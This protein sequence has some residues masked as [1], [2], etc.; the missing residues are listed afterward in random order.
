MPIRHFTKKLEHILTPMMVQWIFKAMRIAVIFLGAAIILEIWGIAVGPLLAGFGLFGVAVALGAQDF[1]KNLIAGMT[2]IAEKRFEPGDWV[3]VDGVVEGTVES[4]GFRSTAIRRF[5]KA[6]VHVPNAQLSDTALTNFS[7]MTHRRIYW[8]IGVVYGSSVEQLKIVRDGIMDYIQNN[9]AFD[10]G[11]STFVRIDSFN[12][13]S[14]DI[15]V[16]CFTK[17]TDW[18]EWLDIKEQFAFEVKDIV[19]SRAGTAFA[20]PSTSIYVESL[21]E[22]TPEAFIPPKG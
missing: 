21:P 10:K 4:I 13:S 2:V 7:R 3:K 15:M 12:A 11:P 22:N 14:I 5:D 20:F 19:E 17:T 18:G 9:D 8:N 16:Y 6:P 1:F